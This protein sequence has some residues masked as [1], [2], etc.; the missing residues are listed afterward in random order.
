MIMPSSAY[1][2]LKGPGVTTKADPEPARLSGAA[3]AGR[4]TGAPGVACRLGPDGPRGQ[5]SLLPYVG[6]RRS[7]HLT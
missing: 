6:L 5:G 3:L 2:G 4:P 1:S 7:I